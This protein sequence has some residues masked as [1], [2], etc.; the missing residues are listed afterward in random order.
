MDKDRGMEGGTSGS[1]GAMFIGTK[2]AAAAAAGGGK[3]SI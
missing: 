2:V 3:A 1:E